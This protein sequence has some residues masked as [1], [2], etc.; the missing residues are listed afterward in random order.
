MNNGG[1]STICQNNPG[2]YICVCNDGYQI[3]TDGTQC[4]GKNILIT[5]H[6]I[7]MKL[8]FYYIIILQMVLLLVS[9]LCENVNILLQI[10]TSVLNCLVYA[11]EGNA[12]T[13]RGA[14]GV[15]V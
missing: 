7:W 3:Q 12:L 8:N 11:V 14:T 1:C 13:C 4:E 5:K 2:S 9:Y 10:S 6:K 15:D